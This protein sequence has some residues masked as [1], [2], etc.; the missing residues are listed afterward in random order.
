MK[1]KGFALMK[2]KD[3]ESEVVVEIEFGGFS[4]Y[5][6]V[7]VEAPVCSAH[8]KIHHKFPIS[9]QG[10]ATSITLGVVKSM[11]GSSAALSPRL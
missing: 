3:P 4:T 1:A 7:A 8:G 2:R 6:D 10:H 11:N 9:S 5:H